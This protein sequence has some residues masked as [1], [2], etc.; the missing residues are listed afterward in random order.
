MESE[1]EVN[2]DEVLHSLL[3]HDLRNKLQ[4]AI[5]YLQLLKDMDL[6]KE[7]KDFVKKSLKS[8]RDGNKLIEKVRTIRGVSEKEVNS[9]E[10]GKFIKR[11]IE[12]S[13]KL[14]Y[15]NISINY[16]EE[17]CKVKGG[18]LLEH[19][20]F[21]LISNSIKHADCDRIEINVNRNEEVCIV[22]VKDD[23]IGIPPK[24]QEELFEI[25]SKGG[26]NA[27]YGLGL[28]LVEKIVDHYEGEIKIKRSDDGGSQFDVILN[29]V[30]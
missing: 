5:G 10:V 22:S 16:D 7:Q 23:G 29:K 9:V 20:F 25:G 18:P 11:A 8:L 13:R 24:L 21:N 30:S 19:L 14:S 28:H 17:S 27:G 2:E 6:P 26:E 3:R 1:D 12:E 4:V 15:N